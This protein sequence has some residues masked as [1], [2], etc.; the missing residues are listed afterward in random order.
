MLGEDTCD[1]G[2]LELAACTDRQTDWSWTGALSGSGKKNGNYVNGRG[3]DESEQ[4]TCLSVLGDIL[5]RLLPLQR[6][7]SFYPFWRATPFTRG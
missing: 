7:S 2:C 1:I 3:R 4:G 6:Q 5:S